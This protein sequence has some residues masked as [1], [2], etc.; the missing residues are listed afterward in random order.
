MPHE[1]NTPSVDEVIA[2]MPEEI[3][4]AVT[5]LGFDKIAAAMYAVPEI[6]EEAIATIIGT[7]L[8]AR[9]AARREIFTGLAALDDLKR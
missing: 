9:M 8:A 6:N 7:K 3:K 2:N 5:Q 4:T 1:S